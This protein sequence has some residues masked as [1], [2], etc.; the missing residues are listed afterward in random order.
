MDV[1]AINI[2]LKKMMP[3]IDDSCDEKDADDC[4]DNNVNQNNQED[5]GE[6]IKWQLLHL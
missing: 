3:I 5:N 6:H 2:L 4:D 1:T